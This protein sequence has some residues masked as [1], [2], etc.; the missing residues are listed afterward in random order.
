MPRKHHQKM[1]NFWPKS[2]AIGLHFCPKFSQK[3]WDNFLPRNKHRKMTNFWPKSKA[4]GLHFC[5]KFNQTK[6]GQCF[7]QNLENITKNDQ[8]LAKK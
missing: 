4:I 1:T 8:F 6:I 3:K 2:K 5:P 7:A